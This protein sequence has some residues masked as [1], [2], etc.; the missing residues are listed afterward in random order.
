[1]RPRSEVSN[2]EL[3]IAPEVK[4][5][6]HSL[7]DRL[8]GDAWYYINE[9]FPRKIVELDELYN[10]DLFDV[11]T[12]AELQAPTVNS[13]STAGE[14]SSDQPPTKK[15]HFEN[16]DGGKE[17]DAFDG[18][19]TMDVRLQKMMD[20]LRPE[21]VDIIKNCNAV[22]IWIQLNIPRIEDGNNF[23]V[24]IQEETVSELSR[25]EEAA[26]AYMENFTKFFITRG[27]VS[28]KV[29]K[30]PGLN[31][32]KVAIRRLDE[33]EWMDLKYLLLEIRNNYSILH[34]MLL[35]NMDKIKKPRTGH[36]ENLY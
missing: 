4:K 22:K 12:L 10:S 34:D 15:R 20:V 33:K 8:T 29:L 2:R 35:K 16:T 13:N 1:M 32:Y 17:F 23:G 11:R 19:V 28:S 6:M 9:V 3:D 21:L 18:T 31:D 5:T 30:Y 26:Y 27:K 36:M 25:A 14:G 7:R 24:S